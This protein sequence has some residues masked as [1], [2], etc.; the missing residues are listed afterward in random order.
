MPLVFSIIVKMGKF[1]LLSWLIRGSRSS[2]SS[3][4]GA[5]VGL[6]LRGFRRSDEVRERHLGVEY[7]K[8]CRGVAVRLPHLGRY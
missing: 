8:A 2:I 3:G 4:S 7:C 1:Q 5:R 6:S